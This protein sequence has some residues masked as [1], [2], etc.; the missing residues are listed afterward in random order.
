MSI[1]SVIIILISITIIVG[2]TPS[3]NQI[4]PQK[5]YTLSFKHSEKPAVPGSEVSYDFVKVDLP[6]I[7]TK[8]MTQNIIYSNA[9]FQKDSYSQSKWKE[10]LPI[11]LQE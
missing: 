8:H 11:M 5:Y 3:V 10:P 7:S 2:C 4:K 9:P 1:K 6:H